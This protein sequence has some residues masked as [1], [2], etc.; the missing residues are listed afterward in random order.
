MR[1]MHLIS[2]DPFWKW[3]LQIL[4][5]GAS[6]TFSNLR[7][8]TLKHTCRPSCIHLWEVLHVDPVRLPISGRWRSWQK[9]LHWRHSEQHNGLLRVQ[10][11]NI[12]A[13]VLSREY[14][15]WSDN[16]AD[17]VSYMGVRIPS[18]WSK[19]RIIRFLH[20]VW[21]GRLC[22]FAPISL[23]WLTDQDSGGILR[24]NSLMNYMEEIIH[25]SPV[26]VPTGYAVFP[27]EIACAPRFIASHTYKNLTS[28]TYQEDGGHFAAFEQPALL[29]KDVRLFVRDI[30]RLYPEQISPNTGFAAKSR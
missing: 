26:K 28:V 29:E 10:F 5:S 21:D 9:V 30:E 3:T 23:T 18:W 14:R 22:W 4:S 17:Q 15:I 8:R 25:R 13:A 7:F 2:E 19:K 6:Q 27:N 11:D 24:E 20:P 16:V 1:H 12:I